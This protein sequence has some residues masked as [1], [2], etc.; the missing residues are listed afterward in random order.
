[1]SNTHPSLQT[2]NG[3]SIKY[4]PDH[5]VCLD[6]VE[7]STSSTSHDTRCILTTELSGFIFTYLAR[8]TGAEAEK[9]PRH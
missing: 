8:L 1:M 6:L 7:T 9:D 5:T 3:R 2:R 4:I